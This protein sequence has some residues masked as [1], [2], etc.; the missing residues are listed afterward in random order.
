MNTLNV[1]IPQFNMI[2]TSWHESSLEELKDLWSERK[3]E[4]LTNEYQ[5]YID[6]YISLFFDKNGSKSIFERMKIA[7]SAATSKEQLT[8]PIFDYFHTV[9]T[10]DDM[11]WPF[12]DND[13]RRWN[14]LHMFITASQFETTV[15][16]SHVEVDFLVRKTNML[17]QI[18]ALFGNCNFRVKLVR[19]NYRTEEKFVVEVC[20]FML[21]Y[22]PD[23]VP[24][25][26]KR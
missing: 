3:K 21:D 18:D 15:E 12:V 7:I 25:Y 23:G 22:F 24:E 2:A 26:M 11:T 17:K 6:R 19:N 10:K 20:E 13:G 14:Q 9:V 16:G 8:V 5:S 4:V 1:E